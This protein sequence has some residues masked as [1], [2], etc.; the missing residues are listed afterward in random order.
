LTSTRGGKPLFFK[1][2]F[3]SPWAQTGS[4]QRPRHGDLGASFRFENGAEMR[5]QE[6]LQDADEGKKTKKRKG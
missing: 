6:Q 2:Y 4:Y 5:E 1:N 3:S